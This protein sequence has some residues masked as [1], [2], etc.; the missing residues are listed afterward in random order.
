MRPG[1]AWECHQP[2]SSSRSSISPAF[3]SACKFPHNQPSFLG[4]NLIKVALGRST[5]PKPRSWLLAKDGR[6]KCSL[7]PTA[8]PAAPTGTLLPV[9]RHPG[10]LLGLHFSPLLLSAAG[11]LKNVRFCEIC[12]RPGSSLSPLGHARMPPCSAT[13]P[14]DLR[15]LPE[16]QLAGEAK[17]GLLEVEQGC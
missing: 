14:A 11:L 6:E 13:H 10:H 8:A 15:V 2:L 3:L 5:S 17:P 7:L 16:L 1:G 4:L 12:Q 9:F